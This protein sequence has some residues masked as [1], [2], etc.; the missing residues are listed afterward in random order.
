ML[1]LLAILGA[2]EGQ[3]LSSAYEET[4][5]NASAAVSVDRA[6]HLAFLV[7][8]LL[9]YFLSPQQNK[10]ELSPQSTSSWQW[11]GQ[12]LEAFAG[13]LHC[14]TLR[15]IFLLLRI[16]SANVASF[17]CR[18]LLAQHR[19]LNTSV[20]LMSARTSAKATGI[21]VCGHAPGTCVLCSQNAAPVG[22]AFFGR[23]FSSGGSESPS[24]GQQSE[25][26]SKPS[27]QKESSSVGTEGGILVHTML[28]AS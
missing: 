26:S 8:F 2:L 14:P 23:C 24:K 22:V 1:L 10:A 19:S 28:H 3:W 4:V 18:M 27:G 21:A 11:L 6:L 12:V 17:L 15:H 20:E 5:V 13:D 25:S 9:Q 16:L 7:S